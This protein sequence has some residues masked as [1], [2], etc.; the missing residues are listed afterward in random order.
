MRGIAVKFLLHYPATD[1]IHSLRYRI[2]V[3]ASSEYAPTGAWD[4]LLPTN[5]IWQQE[6]LATDATFHRFN[7]DQV[8]VMKSR[9]GTLSLG[10]QKNT[11]AEGKLWVPLRRKCR[12]ALREAGLVADYVG[13]LKDKQYYVICEFFDPQGLLINPAVPV[14]WRTTFT[15]QVYF[16]DP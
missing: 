4:V 5:N 2:S 12:I 3:I 15:K 7:T 10:G 6:D 13:E 9:R 16:K 1:L 14:Y 8:K 11:T